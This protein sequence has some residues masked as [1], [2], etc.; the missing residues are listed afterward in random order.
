MIDGKA[1]TDY[2]ALSSLST[3]AERVTQLCNKGWE[4]ARLHAPG[5][6]VSMHGFVC[7]CSTMAFDDFTCNLRRMS[8]Y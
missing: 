6:R 1:G 2:I 8:G 5:H 7:V 4:V 3:A